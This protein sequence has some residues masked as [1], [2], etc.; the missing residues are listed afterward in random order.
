MVSQALSLGSGKHTQGLVNAGSDACD[1]DGT[2][3]P[4]YLSSFLE[5]ACG[6]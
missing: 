3:Q 6:P 4:V 1:I 2:T 5:S